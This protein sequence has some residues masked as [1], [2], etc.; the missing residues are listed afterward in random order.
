MIS[1]H[2]IESYLYNRLWSKVTEAIIKNDMDTATDEKTIIEDRQREDA[3]KREA[4]G[5]E[6]QPKYFYIKYG[7]TYEFKGIST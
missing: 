7:D 4:E 5:K 1:E 2:I 6:F 3:R